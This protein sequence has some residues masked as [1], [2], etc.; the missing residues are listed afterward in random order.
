M[1]LSVSGVLMFSICCCAAKH[2]QNFVEGY[3][4]AADFTCL[5]SYNLGCRLVKGA[6]E[7]RKLLV[8]LR[9]TPGCASESEKMC[10]LA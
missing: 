4:R 1:S 9:P 5:V 2:T 10:Y 6:R 7:M 3:S 8:N